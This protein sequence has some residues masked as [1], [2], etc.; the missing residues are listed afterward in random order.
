MIGS[1]NLVHDLC[2]VLICEVLLLSQKE[3]SQLVFPVC[4]IQSYLGQ[5]SPLWPDCTVKA[6]VLK[7]K[8]TANPVEAELINSNFI[9]SNTDGC[10]ERMSLGVGRRREGRQVLK[11]REFQWVVSR[12]YQLS[13]MV[14]E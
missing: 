2:H 11:Q 13:K 14:R 5:Q 4:L 10:M 7:L 9:T 12:S 6:Q 3:E 1:R 8:Q